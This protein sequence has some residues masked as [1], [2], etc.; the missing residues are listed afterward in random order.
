MEGEPKAN[1]KA[2][3]YVKLKSVKVSCFQNDVGLSSTYDTVVE[4]CK[5]NYK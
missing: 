5:V 1:V 2:G 3:D 4:V